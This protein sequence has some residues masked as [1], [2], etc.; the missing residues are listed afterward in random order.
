VGER[1]A[2]VIYGVPPGPAWDPAGV[3]QAPGWQAEDGFVIAPLDVSL[4][5]PPRPA[6]PQEAR[7][8]EAP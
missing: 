1:R 3:T 2:V 4:A 7:T 6:P 5:R 8:V